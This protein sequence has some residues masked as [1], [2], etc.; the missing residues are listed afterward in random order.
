MASM[1][2]SS[3]FRSGSIA[4]AVAL[5][6]AAQVQAG[7]TREGSEYDL[8]LPLAGDQV[9][10]DM[11]LGPTG[12]FLAWHDNVGDGDGLAVSFRRITSA[13]N[14]ELNVTPL[15]TRTAGNQERPK[16]AL[17]SN[18]GAA[19]V[20]QGGP[21][22]AQQVFLRVL[23]S[24]G[25]FVG[26]EAPVSVRTEADQVQPSVAG[27][28][29]GNI[30]VVWS[31][32]GPD[33]SMQ[34]VF[35]ALFGPTGNKI[36][37]EFQIN[38]FTL[39]NQRSA[40]VSAQ[41]S[42]GF[43]V[44]WVSEGARSDSSVDV[45]ART[46][47]S[48]GL[49]LVSEFR[50]ND[51][52]RVA[53]SPALA[54]TSSGS[55]TVAWCEI[56]QDKNAEGIVVPIASTSGWDIYASGFSPDGG[57]LTAPTRVNQETYGNQTNPSIAAV[58]RSQMV[59]WTSFGQDGDFEG[60]VA[61][62]LTGVGAPDGDETVVNTAFIGRQQYPVV[63]GNGESRFVVAWSSFSG[64]ANHLELKGQRFAAQEDV[65]AL[66]P[67]GAP[68][69]SALS[70]GRLSVTWAAVEGLDVVSYELYMDGGATPMVVTSQMKIVSVPEAGRTY[71]FELAYRLRDGQLSPRSPER[72]GRTWGEDWNEDF[73][74]DDWQT[75]FWGGLSSLWPASNIDSDRDG[76]SNYDEYRAG[77][78]P[79]DPNSVLR[80]QMIFG[81]Q[82]WRLSWNT[83]PG[84]MYQVQQ[85]SDFSVWNDLGGQRFA[86]GTADWVNV[87]AG[88][89]LGY[90]RVNRIR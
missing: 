87:P 17:L 65:I 20:W 30:V 53:S 41:P 72:S 28:A 69:V 82:G 9:Y 54:V 26:E 45:Y 15:A 4:L 46:Y 89:S 70:Q 59:V 36:G 39:N 47:G 66:Q 57:R 11:A 8:A 52:D 13:L 23:N 60:V 6:V 80:T 67:P 86:P 35:G 25:V 49:P 78:N 56:S 79:T 14:G 61:R 24:N 12:G 42:G 22:S 43:V 16:V 21:D 33:G 85:T 84:Q 68:Y 18:G 40:V 90:Y 38:Q 74:P 32:N 1:K 5:G 75:Q 37:G 81:P 3:A 27:L 50:V 48:N 63:R 83:V 10:A 71:S 7:V 2:F 31:S 29:N 34:G 73:M 77:T 88:N 55:F 76:V 62:A 64:L 19:F 58:G 51:S 44:A